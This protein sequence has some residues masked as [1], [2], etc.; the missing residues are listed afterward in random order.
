[1]GYVEP[2]LVYLPVEQSAGTSMGLL[3]RVAG[4]PLVLSPLLQKEVARL[5]SSVPVYDVKAMTDRYSEFLAHPRFRAMIMGIL[6]ALTLLLAAVGIYGVLARSV[7]QRTQ[8]IGVRLA[9]GAEQRDILSLIL[10]Q[11]TKLTLIGVGIG[12]TAAMALTRLMRS[13]LFGVSSTD[14]LTFVSVALLL[15]FVAMLASYIPARRAMRVDP[16]VALRY[17]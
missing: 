8:E 2:V 15:T 6:A 12:I 4:S 10:R 3:L 17:E 9:L 11:G 14:L 16:I 7:S 5:D 1:M 13:L